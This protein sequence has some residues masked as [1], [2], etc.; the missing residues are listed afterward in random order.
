MI[1]SAVP[2]CRFTVAFVVD[3]VF[4][5]DN[6][7]LQWRN[8]RHFIRN[9]SVSRSPKRKSKAW[10]IDFSRWHLLEIQAMHRE[11]RMRAFIIIN[12]LNSLDY[13]V[14]ILYSDMEKWTSSIYNFISLNLCKLV[15]FLLQRVYTF[16][17]YRFSISFCLNTGDLKKCC[18]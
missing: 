17:A 1:D 9:I 5:N 18:V 12:Y 14:Y 6:N 16:S 4:K 15:F 3:V 2:F 8:E 11:Q 13:N 10:L 7:R